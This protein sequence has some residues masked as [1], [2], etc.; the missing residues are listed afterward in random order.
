MDENGEILDSYEVFTPSSG[1]W[2]L[3]QLLEPRSGHTATPIWHGAGAL[4]VGGQN[5]SNLIES[6]EVYVG[7]IESTDTMPNPRKGHTSVALPSGRVLVIGGFGDMS[8]Q[9][10]TKDVA[11]FEFGEFWVPGVSQPP[12][13][14]LHILASTPNGALVAGGWSGGSSPLASAERHVSTGGSAPTIAATTASMFDP[15]AGHA[16]AAVSHSRVVVT[17]GG[18]RRAFSTRPRSI[19]GIWT[20]GRRPLR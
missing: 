12:Q 3:R 13:R 19:T 20:Y 7:D 2:D 14:A 4:I 1:Q 5:D 6:A 10:P 11:L 15:R 8:S 18:T 17:G 16:G 9:Q